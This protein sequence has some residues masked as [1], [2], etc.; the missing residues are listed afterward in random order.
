MKPS[1]ENTMATVL[2][3]VGRYYW[4]R[5]GPP[6]EVDLTFWVGPKMKVSVRLPGYRMTNSPGTAHLVVVSYL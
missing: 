3:R 4:P 6:T 5:C 1:V 2:P